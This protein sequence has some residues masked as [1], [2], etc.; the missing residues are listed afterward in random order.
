MTQAN[1]TQ[2]RSKIPTNER[3]GLAEADLDKLE[4][5]IVGIYRR[6]D[7]LTIAAVG[8]SFL[9]TTGIVIAALTFAASTN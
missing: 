4:I 2:Q 3:L 6:L 5:Q 8:G 1:R 9:L 7:R